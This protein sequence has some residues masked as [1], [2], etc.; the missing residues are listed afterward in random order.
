MSLTALVNSP[1]LSC[2]VWMWTAHSFLAPLTWM[3]ANVI[4]SLW[5]K[6]EKEAHLK[7]HSLRW[8][9]TCSCILPRDQTRKTPLQLQGTRVRPLWCLRAFFSPLCAM[10]AEC[11]LSI[12]PILEIF[13]LGQTC[14]PYMWC[15]SNTV[16]G[17]S[18][19]SQE[20]PLTSVSRYSLLI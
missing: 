18:W 17:R 15:S 10:H 1:M 12:R 3:N 4:S 16:R 20:T 6:S 14:F 13:H 5:V 7:N 9:P 8:Q 11:K 2:N 19:P